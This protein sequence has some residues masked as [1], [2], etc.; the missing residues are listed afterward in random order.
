MLERN[1]HPCSTPATASGVSFSPLNRLCQATDLNSVQPPMTQDNPASQDQPSNLRCPKTSKPSPP[2]HPNPRPYATAVY[3]DTKGAPAHTPSF[4]AL[5]GTSGSE[6]SSHATCRVTLRLPGTST[7]SRGFVTGGTRVR[8]L[9]GC[10]CCCGGS[11][12]GLSAGTPYSTASGSPTCDCVIRWIAP[13]PA[14]ERRTRCRI[15]TSNSSA[16]RDIAGPSDG[17]CEARRMRGRMGTSSS[18]GP[19]VCRMGGDAPVLPGIV[20]D[21]AGARL[22]KPCGSCSAVSVTGTVGVGTACAAS[23]GTEG[24]PAAVVLQA[25]GMDGVWDKMADRGTS[26]LLSAAGPKRGGDNEAAAGS[27]GGAESRR[28]VP[29]R[30]KV[31]R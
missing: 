1:V 10:C 21:G 25:S 27:A 4:G 14:A 31:G 2:P 19:R 15:G 11:L 5:A 12:R 26:A 20:V 18:R 30:L 22:R 9:L 23:V 13:T 6:S 29:S 3:R 24:P 8:G 17:A 28:R 7:V 16:A